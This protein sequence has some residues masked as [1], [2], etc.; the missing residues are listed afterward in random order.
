M[1]NGTKILNQRKHLGMSQV[2]LAEGICTQAT[3][4]KM[5]QKNM[6]PMTDTLVKICVRLGLTVDDVLTDFDDSAYQKQRKILDQVQVKLSESNYK[7]AEELFR[8]LNFHQ[9]TPSLSSRYIYEKGN[10]DL[11][12]HS[13]IEDA[14]FNYGI[15]LQEANG[16]YVDILAAST[17][18]GTAYA[19]KKDFKKAD[20]YFNQA[21]KHAK[22]L[23]LNKE[24][25]IDYLKALNNAASFYTEIKKYLK[26]NDLN[27]KLLKALGNLSVVPY[28]DQTYFRIAINL[29][30]ENPQ[31]SA[32]EIKDNLNKAEA[33]AEVAKNKELLKK[34]DDF[35][36]K[37]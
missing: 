9:I 23:D 4:S 24:N 12:L 21:L 1:L 15:A 13:K 25:I 10:L 19:I 17:G 5:E 32:K 7:K 26:S 30:A 33:F 2:E 35:K 14:I 20:Y 11:L 16:N 27:R 3:L 22:D 18:L 8:Q 6:A 29:E 37:I 36:R 34:I 28:I 31:K